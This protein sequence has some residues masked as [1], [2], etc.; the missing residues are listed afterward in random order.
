L[1]GNNGIYAIA[2]VIYDSLNMPTVA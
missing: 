1:E 2:S